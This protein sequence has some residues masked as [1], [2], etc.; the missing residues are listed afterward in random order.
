MSAN[1]VLNNLTRSREKDVPCHIN[2]GTFVSDLFRST[3]I[4]RYETIDVH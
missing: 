4:T 2:V 3:I 1:N